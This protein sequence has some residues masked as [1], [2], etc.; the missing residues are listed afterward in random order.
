MTSAPAMVE[1]DIPCERCGYDL[2]GLDPAGNCP[3][4]GEEV[5]AS[6]RRW[7]HAQRN[8]PDILECDPR[9]IRSV[10]EGAAIA[11][12]AFAIAVALAFA[13][14]WAFE[15]RSPQRRWTLGV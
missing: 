3:E 8:T 7:E 12:L 10:A 4:C 1:L 5:G 2:R 14:D 11:V 15:W 6:L 9:W 13:P